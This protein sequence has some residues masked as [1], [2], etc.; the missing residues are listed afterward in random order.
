MNKS[1][2]WEISQATRANNGLSDFLKDVRPIRREP[3][4]LID[5]FW[6][7]ALLGQK[8]SLQ[9]NCLKKGNS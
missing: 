6:T 7:P 4:Y 2:R 3:A 5:F 1:N 8:R 9:Q